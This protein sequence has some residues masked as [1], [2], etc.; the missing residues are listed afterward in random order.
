MNQ[1]GSQR[2]IAASSLAVTAVIVVVMAVWGYNAFT[3]P[4]DDDASLSTAET[5]DEVTCAPGEE[6]RI[7]ENLRSNQV[8]VSVYNAGQKKGRA[9]AT[10]NLLED[11]N[12][13]PG[14]IG[15]AADSEVSFVEIHVKESD[16]T[17]AELVALSFGKTATIVTDDE[18]DLRGPGVNVIIGDDFRKLKVGAP[19][20]IKLP[21]P[22]ITCE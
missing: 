10:L 9:T 12:F 17:K 11:R 15:N 14:A 4:I 19:R 8:V 13:Q 21:E 2:T 3:A 18:K 5:T 22:A 6:Q 16:R 20:T 7:V 1:L